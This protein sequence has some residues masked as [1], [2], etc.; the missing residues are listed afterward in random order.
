MKTR[1]RTKLGLKMPP[2]DAKQTPEPFK[3]NLKRCP[4]CNGHSLTIE[5]TRAYYQVRC[6]ECGCHGPITAENMAR[7]VNYW[8]ATDKYMNDSA[9]VFHVQ[10]PSNRN[11]MKEVEL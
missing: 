11:D 6:F 1:T 5:T 2:Y 3:Y 10:P 4:F 7:A 9:L 8:N